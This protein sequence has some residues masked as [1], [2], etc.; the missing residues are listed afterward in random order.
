MKFDLY[1]DSDSGKKIGE[2]EIKTIEDLMALVIKE[3][4]NIWLERDAF[5]N[6]ETGEPEEYWQLVIKDTP[7][8]DY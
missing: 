5:N 8:W 2:V 6:I 4:H 7:A 3:G 1:K